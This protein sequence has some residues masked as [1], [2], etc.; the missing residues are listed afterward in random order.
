MFAT[1]FNTIEQPILRTLKGKTFARPEP[2]RFLCQTSISPV[3]VAD[4]PLT[5]VALGT[6]KVLS[7]LHYLKKIALTQKQES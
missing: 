4:D 1:P 3:H 5:A 2:N 6:G 7:E